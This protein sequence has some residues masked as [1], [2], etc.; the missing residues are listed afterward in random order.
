MFCF[1][2]TPH[3]LTPCVSKD[4]GK[5]RHL[6]SLGFQLGDIQSGVFHLGAKWPSVPQQ[7]SSL[8]STLETVGIWSSIVLCA[9][10]L[11][12]QESTNCMHFL[13]YF[14]NTPGRHQRLTGHCTQ[15]KAQGQG[16]P[17]SWLG[18]WHQLF[19]TRVPYTPLSFLSCPSLCLPFLWSGSPVNSSHSHL[20]FLVFN[21]LWHC[22]QFLP[23]HSLHQKIKS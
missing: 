3:H 7:T 13:I 20:P 14:Q 18:K 19:Y 5:I 12:V 17:P 1:S 11:W 6:C 8:L 23:W 10:F 15:W 22:Q 2:P 21:Q 16:S 4:S 9:V